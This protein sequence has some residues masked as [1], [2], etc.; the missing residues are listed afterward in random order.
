M[1]GFCKHDTVKIERPISKKF[2]VSMI[3]SSDTFI[4]VT[5]RYLSNIFKLN[6]SI[7]ISVCINY[8]MPNKT[9]P[10]FELEECVMLFVYHA[11]CQ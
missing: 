5:I 9:P 10:K 3:A 4:G 1:L 8:F 6:V 7:N 11:L 2:E